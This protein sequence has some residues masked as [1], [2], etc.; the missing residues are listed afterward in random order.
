VHG[1]DPPAERA[2]EATTRLQTVS[3]H[4]PTHT[5]HRR[6]R[7]SPRSSYGDHGRGLR[8]T[9]ACPRT[10]TRSMHYVDPVH[11][12][13]GRPCP[14]HASRPTNRSSR[15]PAPKLTFWPWPDVGLSPPRCQ[16][17]PMPDVA[18]VSAGPGRALSGSNSR[19]GLR[20]RSAE[21]NRV[22][23]PSG[24][25]PAFETSGTHRG[26]SLGSVSLEVPTQSSRPSD[27]GS[28]THWSA[29]LMHNLG[30]LRRLQCHA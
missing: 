10:Q 5:R 27:A 11:K 12:Q 7:Q 4:V 15:G 24:T 22:G 16:Q 18:V 21:M 6:T 3:S 2:G 9:E 28:R 29:R 26:V 17:H 25:P 19:S 23:T 14:P 30:Q 1:P 8:L 13:I 20:H